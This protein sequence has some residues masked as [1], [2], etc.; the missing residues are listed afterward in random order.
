MEKESI[1]IFQQKHT[2]LLSVNFVSI[3][4]TA[5]YPQILHGAPDNPLSID[6]KFHTSCG[7]L[8]YLVQTILAKHPIRF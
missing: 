7:D 8:Y 5:T 1:N 4:F 2:Q 6:L 3:D